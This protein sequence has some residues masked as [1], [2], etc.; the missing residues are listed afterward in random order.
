MYDLA[1]WLCTRPPNQRTKEDYYSYRL[2]P[3]TAIES[4]R[5][6]TLRNT[7]FP[8]SAKQKSKLC[9]RCN[10]VR[11]SMTMST[12]IVLIDTAVN[13]EEASTECF[14][15]DMTLARISSLEDYVSV[16][17][18]LL[19]TTSSGPFWIG[20]KDDGR[21]GVT[22]AA[23]F[24]YISNPVEEE[25]TESGEAVQE[26]QHMFFQHPNYFPWSGGYPRN[27]AKGYN[28]V[29][30]NKG[31]LRWQ[32]MNCTQQLGFLCKFEAS[33]DSTTNSTPSFTETE[34][35]LQLWNEN[36]IALSILG[37]IITVMLC[38]LFSAQLLTRR[39]RARIK[40]RNQRFFARTKQS[41]MVM[42]SME[43]PE[44]TL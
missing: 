4:K 21:G 9:Q 3:T 40:R 20:V 7:T 27:R 31:N 24:T 42:V 11:H 39:K 22:A 6:S 30:I 1:Y 35:F 5:S 28:C 37:G 25:E 14:L 33:E 32:D 41:S 2:P 16:D 17:F 44:Y 18:A 15:R 19:N 43:E 34:P 26:E 23:R 12:G 29:S 10:V 13:F 36:M 8:H 38:L